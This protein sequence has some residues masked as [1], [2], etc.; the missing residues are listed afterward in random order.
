MIERKTKLIIIS[1]ENEYHNPSD[2]WSNQGS[3]VDL[4]IKAQ[5]YM[6]PSRQISFQSHTEGWWAVGTG[7]EAYTRGWYGCYNTDLKKLLNCEINK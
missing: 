2:L 1:N 3:P 5:S 7:P 6:A 4:E